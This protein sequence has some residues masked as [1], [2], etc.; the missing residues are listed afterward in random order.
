M[1]LPCS[2]QCLETGQHEKAPICRRWY[3]IYHSSLILR[4][5]NDCPHLKVVSMHSSVRLKGSLCHSDVLIAMAKG[6]DQ[7]A[8]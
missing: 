1:I 2:V 3:K 5:R 4:H 7:D 8:G 6:K